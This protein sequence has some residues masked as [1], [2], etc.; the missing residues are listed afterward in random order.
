MAQIYQSLEWKESKNALFEAAG[1]ST[2]HQYR[3]RATG[4]EVSAYAGFPERQSWIK[5]GRFQDLLLALIACERHDFAYASNAANAR[6]Q[7]LV[8]A[9]SERT[10]ERVNAL[11]HS[12][13]ED[14]LDLLVDS[15]KVGEGR[16]FHRA[17]SYFE[18][19][20]TGLKQGNDGQFTMTI[21]FSAQNTPKWLI[22][23]SPGAQIAMGAVLLTDVAEHD[24]QAWKQKAAD[25]LVRAHV[26][27]KEVGFAEWIAARYDRWGLVQ[28]SLSNATS[29]DIERAVEETLRR[30]IG[31]PSRRDLLTNRDAVEKLN[32][33]DAE[34]YR[35]LSHGF[36]QYVPAATP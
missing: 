5:L 2:P 33:L 29:E 17:A 14:I 21:T 34:F 26:L 4:V 15:P 16:P 7:E 1:K 27:P 10:R 25:A 8:F 13:A 35:D 9:G 6:G 23:A 11:R 22:E 20:K 28:E 32:T 30:L 19:R 18:A 3:I 12:R 24:L 31:I 36:G